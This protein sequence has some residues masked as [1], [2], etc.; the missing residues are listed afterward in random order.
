VKGKWYVVDKVI[1]N[2]TL[3]SG[4]GSNQIKVDIRHVTDADK[5]KHGEAE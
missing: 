2:G 3:V 1:D 4:I 5:A